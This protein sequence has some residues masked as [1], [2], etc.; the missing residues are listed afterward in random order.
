MDLHKTGSFISAL[1][2]QG[3]MTQKELA[4]R[5]GVTDKAVSRWETGHGFPDVSLLPALAGA[6]SVSV[7]DIVMGEKLDVGEG[8]T[9]AIMDQTVITT[10]QYSQKKRS[11]R[12]LFKYLIIAFFGAMVLLFTS[13]ALMIRVFG[14]TEVFFQMVYILMM[15]FIIPIG[16]PIVIYFL[17]RKPRRVSPRSWLWICPVV[18]FLLGLLASALVFPQYFTDLFVDY[19]DTSRDEFLGFIIPVHC[20]ISVSSTAIC[21]A[22]K[23]LRTSES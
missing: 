16:T 5:I 10:L 22:I 12:T 23:R 19:H 9:L 11:K 17:R 18:A 14:D 4:D 21:H 2:K 20:L 7:S 1:R 6:L 13:A 8:N 3:K 15:F